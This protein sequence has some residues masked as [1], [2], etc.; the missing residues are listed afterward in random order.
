M[1]C[2][3][4]VLSCLSSFIFSCLAS[5]S[6]V[7]SCLVTLSLSRLLLSRLLLSSFS[8]SLSLSVSVFFLCLSLFPSFPLSPCDAVCDVVLCC[9]VCVWCAVC[10]CVLRHAE[11]N[12]EKNPCV[13]SK[14]ARV[15]RHHAHTCFKMCA[16]CRHT[17]GRFEGTH[18][19]QSGVIVSSAYQNL[20]T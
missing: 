15:Y 9:V 16:W 13:H 20:P 18:G 19:G 17:R 7:S 10:V 6:L 4:I 2:I 1:Y 12:V 11:K 8:V 14:R 3:Y 5:S